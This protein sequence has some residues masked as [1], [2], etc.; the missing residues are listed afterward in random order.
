MEVARDWIKSLQHLHPCRWA[1]TQ[2]SSLE[3]PGTVLP[4][5]SDFDSGKLMLNIGTPKFLNPFCDF[6][7]S[8]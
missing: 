6:N 5:Q 8:L 1:E 2:G 7:P 4:Y 3:P